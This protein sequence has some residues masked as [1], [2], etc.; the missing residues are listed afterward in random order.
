[1][2]YHESKEVHFLKI[3]FEIRI[4]CHP[5]ERAHYVDSASAIV[6]HFRTCAVPEKS[7]RKNWKI[8]VTTIT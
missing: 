4:R 8:D 6:H 2:D 1:M 5:F 3:Y 7:K